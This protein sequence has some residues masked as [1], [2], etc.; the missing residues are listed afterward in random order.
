MKKYCLILYLCFLIT[1]PSCRDSMKEDAEIIVNRMST[2]QKIGQ[3]LMVGI[4]GNKISSRSKRIIEKYLPGGI[5]L[6]GYNLLTKNEVKNFIEKLQQIS[7]GSSNIPLFISVDEE[8]GRVKRL[9]DGV[10]HFPGNMD[11]AVNQSRK[12]CCV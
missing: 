2:E 3:M 10:T 1:A 4:P 12:N 11:M 6:Y 7:I 8:G 5:V 9:T